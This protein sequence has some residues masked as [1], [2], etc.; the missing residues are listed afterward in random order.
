[1]TLQEKLDRLAEAMP[2]EWREVVGWE[3]L[4]LVTREGVVKS[5]P[6]SWILNGRP[7]TNPSKVLSPYLTYRGY[8]SVGLCRG[9]RVKMTFVHK[10]VAAAFIGPKPDGTQINHKNGVKTDN[11]AENLEYVTPRQNIQHA[12]STGLR[13]SRRHLCLAAWE[14]ER[15]PERREGR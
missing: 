2:E 13:K 10:I 3:G 5:L 6:R 4:Y 8:H 14:R 12:L 1:M 15:T 11:R 9:G 7:T